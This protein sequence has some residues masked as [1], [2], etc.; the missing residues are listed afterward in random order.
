MEHP[1]QMRRFLRAVSPEHDEIQAEMATY[2]EE[3]G[4]PTIG[5]EA[6]GAL[7]TLARLTDASRVF[8]FGS[9]YG[10][11][12]AWFFRGMDASGEVILTEHDADELALAR[13]FLERAGVA[14]RATFEGGDALE[15]VEQYDGPFD[16]VLVDHQKTRYAEAFEAARD[17]ISRGGVVVADNVTG[18][19]VDF[20]ALAAHVADGAPLPDGDAS[21]GGIADYLATVSADEAFE[22][23]V[24]PVGQ[25]LAVST[26][27]TPRE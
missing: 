14:E 12:A 8:E 23:L 1:D 9:G 7:L 27:V 18:G 21:T 26:R 16:I 2:A 24:L 11:S 5:R 17:L 4:F 10:Y 13:E 25:G 20:P 15:I 3:H 19:P 6:G 22:T